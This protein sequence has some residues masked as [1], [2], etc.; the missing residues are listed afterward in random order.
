MRAAEAHSDPRPSAL[1]PTVRARFGAGRM[2]REYLALYQRVMA[3]GQW[4]W[5]HLRACRISHES[6]DA[7]PLAAT[8]VTSGGMPPFASGCS[9]C[10]CQQPGRHASSPP[11]ARG[12]QRFTSRGQMSPSISYVDNH[13]STP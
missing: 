2:A 13:A 8:A 6:H 1:P 10:T 5:C 9:F 11:R 12:R 4:G 7:T 3:S